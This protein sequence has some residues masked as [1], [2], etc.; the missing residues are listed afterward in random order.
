MPRYLRVL[1]VAL[2]LALVGMAASHVEAQPLRVVADVAIGFGLGQE[3]ASDCGFVDARL[4]GCAPLSLGLTAE[5][6]LHVHDRVALFVDGGLSQSTPNVTG[7]VRDEVIS[8]PLD[9][10]ASSVALGARFYAQPIYSPV[11]PFAAV[12]VGWQE[13]SGETAVLGRTEKGSVSSYGF[14]VSP[15]VDI[16][17]SDRLT[18]RV[19]GTVAFGFPEGRALGATTNLGIRAG[20]VLRLN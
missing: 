12:S 6:A 19:V 15:G 14:G 16:E 8:A 2:S 13:V 11:R 18:Y 10:Q 4:A 5:F 9:F 1:V 7:V 3:L 17:F 20:I